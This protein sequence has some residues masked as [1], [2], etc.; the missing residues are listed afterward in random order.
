MQKLRKRAET[1]GAALYDEVERNTALNTEKEKLEKMIE[2]LTE[3]RFT[4]DAGLYV[5]F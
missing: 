1:T 5:T 3:V 4:L 2:K